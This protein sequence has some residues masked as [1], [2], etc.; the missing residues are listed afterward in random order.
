MLDVNPRPIKDFTTDEKAAILIKAPDK[1]FTEIM[2]ISKPKSLEQARIYAD[3]AVQKSQEV[4][5]QFLKSQ[6]NK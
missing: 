2:G 4:I 5:V 3:T 6:E 1:L